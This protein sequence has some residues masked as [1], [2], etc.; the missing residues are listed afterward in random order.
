MSHA[1]VLKSKSFLDS[2]FYSDAFLMKGLPQ[3]I[4]KV[5]EV[6]KE[7]PYSVIDSYYNSQEVVQAFKPHDKS[8]AISYPIIS[9]LPFERIYCDTMYLTQPNS[10]LGF[11]NIIDLFSKYAFSRCF[12][13]KSKTSSISSEKAKATFNEFMDE[14]KKYNI[15][16]G[17]V[18]TDR[19]S[20]YMGDFQ[21]NLESK[22]IIQIFANT[23]DKRKTAP[24]ERFN[25]TLRLMLEKFKL[26]YGNINSK[27]LQTIMLSY[28][29]ISH[30]NLKDSPIDILKSKELQ[31]KITSANYQ[32]NNNQISIPSLKGDVRILIQTN[33]FKKVSPIWS[34][35]IYKI[36][37]YS[38]GNYSLEGL[39][40]KYFKRD[41]L[42][43]VSREQVLKPEKINRE[44]LPVEKRDIVP[45]EIEKRNTRGNKIDYHEV[46]KKFV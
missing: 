40:N 26:V 12:I 17:I 39:P 46:F 34:R 23:G 45:A 25:K 14:V 4:K 31:D 2:I 19:G 36:K 27:V 9:L 13:L 10:V 8:V 21:T 41:E 33:A 1:E 35:E 3:F 5:R 43:P 38:S 16:I 20:E 22:S 7:I 28:N 29:N 15:P 6:N 44:A 32:I 18:Y 30:A 24:I 11:V 37:S 42:L